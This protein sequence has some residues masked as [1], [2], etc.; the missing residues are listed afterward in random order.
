MLNVIILSVVMLSV[1]RLNAVLLYVIMLSFVAPQNRPF[2]AQ[3]KNRL[4]MCIRIN[5]DAPSAD[6]FCT[7]I[8]KTS[9]AA[10]LW[11]NRLACFE[12]ENTFALV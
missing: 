9:R 3:Y 12:L 10:V 5:L 2:F 4:I 8:V 11:R 7:C 1:F 6:Y